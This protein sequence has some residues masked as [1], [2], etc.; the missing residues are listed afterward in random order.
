M[1]LCPVAQV[2]VAHDCRRA[3]C[4]VADVHVNDVEPCAQSG[5]PFAYDAM[6]FILVSL[7]EWES[8]GDETVV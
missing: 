2:A 5:P 8:V 1:M 3:G 6:V 7:S 4:A